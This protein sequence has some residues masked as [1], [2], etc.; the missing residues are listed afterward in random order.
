MRLCALLAGVSVLF[1]GC[2]NHRGAPSVLPEPSFSPNPQGTP[3]ILCTTQG[4][5]QSVTRAA[6][7]QTIH[8]ARR[9]VRRRP[10]TVVY[11][12][13]QVEVTYA[14]HATPV[15]A[16][17]GAA[18]V[19][20]FESSRSGRTVRVLRVRAGRESEAM[21]ALRAGEGVLSVSRSPVRYALST[22]ALFTNDPYYNGFPPA[23]TPPLYESPK[24]PGQWDMHEICAANAWG[25]SQNNTTG[26]NYA[27]AAGGTVPIAIVDTGADLTHPELKGRVT[28]AESVINGAVTTGIGTMHDYDGH[29][30][31]VTGIAAATGNN[32]LGFAGVAYTVPLMIFRVFPDPPSGG[33]P[34][35]STDPKCSANPSDIGRAITDAVS[36]GARVINLSLGSSGADPAEE[37]AVAAAIAKGV[38]VVAASG[39]GGTDTLDYPA[40]DPGVIP[41]GASALDDSTSTITDKV[42]SYSNYDSTNP[43]GWGLVAPGGD[44]CP[45]STSSTC[46][47]KD[48]LHWIENVYTHNAADGSSADAC[49]PDFG[50]SGPVDCRILIAGTSMSS[51]HVAGAVALLLSVDSSL[52]PVSV[53][54]ALC[55]TATP[56]T[57][58]I[59]E[60]GCGRLNVYAAMANVLGDPSP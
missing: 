40:H 45:D 26:S 21:D 56:V 43:T 25:Y 8:V 7:L 58:G 55:S 6:S 27:G 3:S 29:G 1:A 33:C 12:P 22:T 35:Q 39:N 5:P 31:D 51:P 23:N 50:S 53:F 13:G 47:D 15:I 16:R 4:A 41:V 9:A 36:R 2:V 59:G 32:S 18:V 38:V 20:T 28:Y 19:E 11:V 49:T 37:N 14:P 54:Q 44:P 42:A 10:H 17:A 46:A 57:T 52:S 34:P 30:T 60:Q 24:I 48:N